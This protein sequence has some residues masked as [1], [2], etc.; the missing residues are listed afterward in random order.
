M[1][2]LGYAS[3]RRF[4]VGAIGII[5]MS[6]LGAWRELLKKTF[7]VQPEGPEM[8]KGIAEMEKETGTS[9]EKDWVPAF[10]GEAFA[11]LYPPDDGTK[12]PGFIISIDNGNGGT[13]TS[14]ARKLIGKANAGQFDDK[15]KVRFSEQR[16]GDL[17]VFTPSNGNDDYFLGA[18]EDQV[19][20]FSKPKLLHEAAQPNETLPEGLRTFTQGDRAQMRFQL[21]LYGLVGMLDHM[22][23]APKDINLKQVLSSRSITMSAQWDEASARMEILIPINIPELIRVVGKEAKK[24]MPPHGAGSDDGFEFE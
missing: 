16:L 3:L 23:E 7:G 10:R 8:E 5:G 20:L 22:G 14:L 21:D 11:A 9:F 12:E 6:N 4:P 19:L 15:H 13:A 17:S 18:S 1:K 24:S 2:P